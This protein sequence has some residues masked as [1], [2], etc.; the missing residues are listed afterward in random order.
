MISLREAWHHLATT[1]VGHPV[2]CL[3]Y[4]TDSRMVNAFQK[5]MLDSERKVEF[6]RS[7]TNSNWISS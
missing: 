6:L 2:S 1:I 5:R 7:L 3:L 4:F